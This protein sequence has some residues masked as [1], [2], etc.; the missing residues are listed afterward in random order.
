LLL[1]IV[2]VFAA[3]ALFAKSSAVNNKSVSLPETYRAPGEPAR[4]EPWLQGRWSVPSM[5]DDDWR[6]MITASVTPKDSGPWRWGNPS[7]DPSTPD[8]SP[9]A[10]PS[11]DTAYGLASFYGNDTHTASGERFNPRAMTA[12]HRTLPFGTRVRVTDV[13]TGRSVM[14]RINDRGPFI[15]GRIIDISTAAAESLGIVGR[16]IA[17]VRVDVVEYPEYAVA[18]P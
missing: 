8:V 9:R 18:T 4:R 16:G 11:R 5:T 3:L 1:V 7:T 6:N 13:V 15:R 2:T 17:R 14:V 10:L 12:A